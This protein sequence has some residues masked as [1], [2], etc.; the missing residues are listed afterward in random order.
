MERV[1][2]DHQ[3]LPA[4]HGEGALPYDDSVLGT[5]GVLGYQCIGADTQNSSSDTLPSGTFPWMG[6]QFKTIS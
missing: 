4:S 5:K 3:C 2:N 1:V 6:R